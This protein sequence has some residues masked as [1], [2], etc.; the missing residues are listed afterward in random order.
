[1]ETKEK[2]IHAAVQCFLQNGYEKASISMITGLC[3]ITKGAFYHHFKNK[4][5]IFFAVINNLF[6]EIDKWIREKIYAAETIKELILNMLDYS[7]YFSESRFIDDMTTHHY[8]IIL[9]AIKRFPDIKKK[10]TGIYVGCMDLFE[11]RL[12]EAQ[13]QGEI[14]G[15][16]DPRPFSVHLFSLAEGIMFMSVL[17]S[18]NG[19]LME[20]G[21]RIAQDLWEMVR[22]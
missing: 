1:M 6:Y 9:D 14:K 13:I 7:E 22:K 5:E 4:D 18:E 16:I 19:K 11:Q 17:A 20:H 15:H 8:S 12:S 2:L 3:N 10:I 21:D